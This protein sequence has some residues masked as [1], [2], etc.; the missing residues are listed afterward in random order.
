MK[1]AFFMLGL[2]F[3]PLSFANEINP[4]IQHYLDQAK[5]KRLDQS[6]T[7]QRLMY[8]NSK[9]HSEV[10]YSGYFLAE[11]GKTDLKKEIQHNIQ[12]LFGST[13]PNQ[14]IRCKFPARSSWLMQQL[15]ISEQQL[16]E[17]SCPDFDR[18]IAEVKPYQ[19][20]LIYAT[21]FMGNP[22]S[23]F[24]HTLL[25]L[26]PKDQQQLN[27]ISYA[28]NYAA[29]VDGN[30]NWSFAW[31]GLTGQYPGEYSLM[32]YY[33]KVKEY[34]DFESRDL[35]EYELNLTPQETRFLV[36]HLWE[37]QKV[38]FPYYFINDNCAY[39]L[40]GL[41]DLV[42]PELNLQKQFN[43]T[44]I[45]I[46]T[47]KVVEQQGL[48]KQ[49]VYRPALETQLLAQS[50]Q[51]GK[52]LAK[53]AH[54]LAYAETVEMPAILQA[55]PAED[56]AKILEM[57]Y[58]H[59]YLDFLRQKIDEPFAQP[60]FRKL[61][62]LRSQL[63]IEKQRATPQR[64]HTDPVQSHHARNISIQAGQVQ[65]ESFVQLGQRQAYHDL[66]DPQ[67]GLRTGT[68][69]LFLDG[70]LQYRDS[71]LKLEHLELLAV[72]SYNPIN[73]FNTPLSWGFNLGWKQEALDSHGQFSEEQKHGVASLK[74][75]VGYS[76]ANASREYLCYAQMQS[77]VQ[78][79]KALDQGWRVGAGPTL[80]CQNIWNDQIN[81][82]VQVEL[83]YWED[84]HRWHLKL[85]TQLQ[86][87]F[88]AQ[89]AIRLS[90]EYQQQQDQDWDQW[91]L[92]LIRYF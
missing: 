91:S 39:R 17:V 56:Q 74:T 62:G 92:G 54:Q 49:K 87:A 44:A 90:W 67:G 81:S 38:S 27:L 83:P 42:R 2:A 13:E 65:G 30:D 16:P 19:A 60:R 1:Y 47:L 53:T 29:T 21:D 61:L 70:A 82:L 10:D 48:I 35:W 11:Q 18:W 68:Q 52:A 46:E 85:N 80:G 57:A 76:W 4:D 12:A 86:Y 43:S 32:P 69:L 84:S 66:I 73:P 3:S 40:L 55:Y 23:M 51:H 22:S 64:P 77:Q 59:L 5:S 33:R 75:Q 45:P 28:V 79:G 37:M 34:G 41:F 25:R 72:N 14:S 31:K 36:Q 15:D 6:T 7:W 89:N 20:T 50:R 58:D 24:G 88:T 8:A 71:E 9:G 63:D 26:D 78:A